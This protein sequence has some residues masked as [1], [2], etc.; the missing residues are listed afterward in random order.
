M[1]WRAGR[2]PGPRRDRQGS[3]LA[4]IP[5]KDGGASLRRH[6]HELST[7]PVGGDGP[8]VILPPFSAIFLHVNLERGGAILQKLHPGVIAVAPSLLAHRALDLCPIR[9]ES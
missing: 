1:R 6:S 3:G 4:G 5:G 2:S 9:L 7:P 8:F